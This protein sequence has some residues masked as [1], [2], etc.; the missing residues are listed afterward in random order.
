[1]IS[2][3][4]TASTH[5]YYHADGIGNVTA[6]ANT[7][8][9]IVAKYVYDAFGNLIAKSGPLAD[10][11][12]Y[13]FSS[14]EAHLNSGLVYYLYRYYDANLQRWLNRDPLGD[15]A[16]FNNPVSILRRIEF[17]PKITLTK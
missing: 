3:L 13:R 9:A 11:N 2:I 16:V 12:L 7:S 6:L 10:A 8:A 17:M 15:F 14:K 1:S 5:A 4:P